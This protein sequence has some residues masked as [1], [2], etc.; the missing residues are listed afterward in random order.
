MNIHTFGSKHFLG[1]LNSIND[2]FRSFG[3]VIDDFD[4]I[5]QLIYSNDM[6]GHQ[7]A[8]KHKDYYIKLGYAP[9]LILNILDIPFHVKEIDEIIQNCKT[10]LPFADRVT[11]ISYKVKQDLLDQTGFNPSVIYQPIRPIEHIPNINKTIDFFINGRVL[12]PNKRG[13]LAEELCKKM[14]RNLVCAGSD[15]LP[16]AKN[17]GVVTDQQLSLLYNMSKI[18]LAFGKIEGIAMQIPESILLKTP[19]IT[20]SD[21][22]TNYEFCP[23]EMICEPNIDAIMDKAE[24]ILSNYS[25]YQNLC[26]ELSEKYMIQFSPKSVA[27]NILQSYNSIYEYC[28]NNS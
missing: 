27:N 19:I 21:N 5:P 4:S 8:V 12:D 6:G 24:N 13:Y 15:Y 2:G 14:N 11:T 10:L 7:S 22:P 3:H 16:S 17:I 18:T 9:R 20:L 23:K 28:S 1:T 26:V 25:Y